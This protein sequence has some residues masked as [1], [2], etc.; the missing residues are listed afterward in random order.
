MGLFDKIKKKA[1]ELKDD[2]FDKDDDKKEEKFVD[3]DDDV[4]EDDVVDEDEDEDEDEEEQEDDN[5]DI[6]V[7][8]MPIGWDKYTDE[9]ILGR[10][11]IVALEY[12]QKGDDVSVLKKEGFDNE[13][14][15]M[16]FKTYFETS[17]AK[18]KGISIYDVMGIS[19]RATQDMMMKNAEGMKG[20]G[21]IMEPVQG[22]SCEEWAKAN[23]AIASGKPADEAYKLIGVDAAKWDA[24][25]NE[26]T[27]RMSNDT[28][29]TIM[30]VYSKAFTASS[31]GNLGGLDQINDTNFPFEK[32][33][34]VQ[35]AQDKLHAQGKDP[36]QILG[37]FGMT[38]T[39]WSNASAYWTQK[40]ATDYEKYIKEDN[41]LRPIYEEKYK[42]GSVHDDIEF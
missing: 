8:K 32:W 18:K 20:S 24:V 39:D 22:I 42:A 7:V 40:M 10:I 1:E 9:E 27:T 28:S 3:K 36:Q 4:D 2:L 33:L 16:G 6:D 15:L 31:T 26:W 17:Y 23:A 12:N 35:V 38:V 25:N 11:S 5:D 41:R 34:E 30:Q 29:F 14:H 21:G 37:S 19:T 13:D